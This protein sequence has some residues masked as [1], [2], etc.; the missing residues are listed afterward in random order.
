[1]SNSKFVIVKTYDSVTEANIAKAKLLA[2]DIFCFLKDENLI[3]IHPLLSNAT[4]GIK[5]MVSEGQANLAAELLNSAATTYKEDIKCPYC[6]ST[7]V[8]YISSVK[9]IKNWISF[10]WAMI[11]F[12]LPIYLK[13]VYHCDNCGKEFKHLEER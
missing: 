3:S 1:M 11:T 10:F 5:L 12:T 8:H 9:D 6:F 7:N 2:S 13:K 4:G